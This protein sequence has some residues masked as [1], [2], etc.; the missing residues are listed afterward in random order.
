MVESYKG[1]IKVLAINV[2]ESARLPMAHQLIK[3]NKL[4]WPHV[5]TGQGEKDPMWKVFWEH[6]QQWAIDT[7]IC[8]G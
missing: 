8:T 1:K 5:A 7:A 6:E 3:E 4:T 2:D